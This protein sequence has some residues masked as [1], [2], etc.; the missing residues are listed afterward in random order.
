MVSRLRIPIR[1]LLKTLDRA[2]GIFPVPLRDPLE[3]RH[4]N[5]LVLCLLNECIY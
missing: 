2:L 3:V 5:S 4:L 1:G